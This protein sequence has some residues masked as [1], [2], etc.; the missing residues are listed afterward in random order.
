M[1]L[2]VRMAGLAEVL[3]ETVQSFELSDSR[4]GVVTEASVDNLHDVTAVGRMDPAKRNCLNSAPRIVR[5]LDGYS[6]FADDTVDS[7]TKAT[8]FLHP[9]EELTELVWTSNLSADAADLLV[10]LV[11]ASDVDKRCLV[12]DADTADFNGFPYDY[13]EILLCHVG[14]CQQKNLSSLQR[15]G[16]RIS[17]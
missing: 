1:G 11:I 12:S 13:H 4:I 17:F 9:L 8:S 16:T 7:F 2:V 10:A 5:I 6:E 14:F 15:E 3:E